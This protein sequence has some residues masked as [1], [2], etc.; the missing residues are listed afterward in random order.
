[1]YNDIVCISAMCLKLAVFFSKDAI[2][3]LLLVCG[4]GLV[5]QPMVKS[6]VLLLVQNRRL[7]IRR[8]YLPIALATKAS[9]NGLRPQ[10]NPD[11]LPSPRIFGC[12]SVSFREF[13]GK[14]STNLRIS[15]LFEWQQ[16]MNTTLEIWCGFFLDIIHDM[17]C[18][19][20]VSILLVEQLGEDFVLFFL[21]R[22]CQLGWLK[23][24]N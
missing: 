5:H 20:V 6:V 17:M 11:G 22:F 12:G 9:E 8:E 16:S 2:V 18:L 10:R 24:H 13:L 23:P 4:V 3:P 14:T 19:C 21:Q 1:M 15:M 7:G